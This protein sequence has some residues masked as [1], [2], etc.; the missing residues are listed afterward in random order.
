MQNSDKESKNR[1]MFITGILSAIIYGLWA[2]YVNQGLPTALAS[3]LAQAISSFIGGYLVAGI[4]EF[5]FSITPKPWRFPV[6]A[7]I[8]Y[9]I[10]LSIYALVHKLVGTPD[11]L[12]TI[13]PNIIIGTPYF[14]LYCIKLEKND[15]LLLRPEPPTV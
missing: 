3:S 6:S 12:S 7:F 4:I 8:P 11:I 13:L 5:T 14:I 2:Y 10:T 15:A 1:R 9:A